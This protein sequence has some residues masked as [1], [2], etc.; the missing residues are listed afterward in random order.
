VRPR[1]AALSFFFALLILGSC[2][3][4]PQATPP[5]TSARHERIVTLAP[6]LAELVYAAGAGDLLVGVSAY[7]DYPPE[8]LHLPVVGDAFMIDQERLSILDPDLLLVWHGG[9]PAHVV[10]EL[11]NAGY[12]VRVMRT[13]TLQDVA[14]SINAIGSLTG[15][16]E[17]AREA[18][19]EFTG[20]LDELRSKQVAK[21]GISVFYQVSRRPLF[22]IS[23]GHYISEL[24]ELCGGTNVF[25]D[26][27][28]LAPTID[29]EAVVERDPEVM[30]A[31][32]DAGDDAFAE[33]GR[34]P[35]IA[36]NRYGN[37]FQMPADEIGRATPRLAQ[38][39]VSVC[40]ALDEARA[41]RGAG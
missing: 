33:W 4:A 5:D 28:D 7:S 8:V 37:H 22:T 38:A 29:V 26:L 15:R 6:N 14:L 2:S 16:Q 35:D 9:T 32:M 19:E 30:M 11:R 25:A 27:G 10:D 24:I 31:S 3:E 17:S 21:P 23:S 20:E 12:N 1:A 18:V 13:N 36:A 40:A 34:W 39:A 41:R